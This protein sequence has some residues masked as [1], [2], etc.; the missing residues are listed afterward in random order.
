MQQMFS[1]PLLIRT[2]GDRRFCTAGDLQRTNQASLTSLG[3]RVFT[4][5]ASRSDVTRR[6]KEKG[7]HPPLHAV[8]HQLDTVIGR[9]QP[10]PPLPLPSGGVSRS[11]LHLPS[12]SPSHS[13][14][15]PPPPSSVCKRT[16]QFYI[17]V[18]IVVLESYPLQYQM[19]ASKSILSKC[20]PTPSRFNNCELC[21]I[22]SLYPP[23]SLP[24]SCITGLGP[25]TALSLASGRPKRQSIHLQYSK[26]RVGISRQES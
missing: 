16:K 26:P 7:R 1:I 18:H 9:L 15:Q 24:C 20:R 10:E 3:V 11:H 17:Y 8:I 4:A 14:Y 19:D 12:P 21:L 22:L 23:R 25:F 5:V 6:F 2:R 13:R